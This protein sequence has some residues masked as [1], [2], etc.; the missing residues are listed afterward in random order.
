MQWCVPVGERVSTHVVVEYVG[1][2]RKVV[3]GVGRRGAL[4]AG[5]L[6]LGAGVRGRPARAARRAARPAHRRRTRSR[7]RA[8]TRS[9]RL[10]ATRYAALCHTPIQT[11]T[12]HVNSY[13]KIESQE[14]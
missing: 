10:L 7:S 5:A 13:R 9:R 4:L 2:R 12:T 1:R 11:V 6:V 8:R 14:I 3:V